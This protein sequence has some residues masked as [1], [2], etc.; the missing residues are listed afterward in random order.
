[1]AFKDRRKPLILQMKPIDL[2]P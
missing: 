1:M 2:Q